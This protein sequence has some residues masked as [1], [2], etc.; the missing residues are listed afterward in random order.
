MILIMIFSSILVS[1]SAHE[2]PFQSFFSA[3]ECHELNG[4]HS[5]ESMLEN[6]ANQQQFLHPPE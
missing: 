2:L 3:G 1:C 4:M 6:N 5:S